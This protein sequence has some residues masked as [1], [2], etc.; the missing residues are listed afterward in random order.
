M[1]IVILCFFGIKSSL[2]GVKI[3]KLDIIKCGIVDKVEIPVINVV[4]GI[5]N[6]YK[7]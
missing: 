3:A 6:N 2:Q 7:F 4:S 1:S 5:E